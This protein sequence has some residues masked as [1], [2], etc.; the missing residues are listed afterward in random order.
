MSNGEPSSKRGWRFLDAADWVDEQFETEAVQSIVMN[1][2]S[3]KSRFLDAA[4]LVEPLFRERFPNPYAGET[5]EEFAARRARTKPKRRVNLVQWPPE[6]PERHG[7]RMQRLRQVRSANVRSA[8]SPTRLPGS[9]QT[10]HR[11]GTS[12]T[13]QGPLG[14]HASSRSTSSAQ[15]TTQAHGARCLPSE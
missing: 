14:T 5:D 12:G 10:V 13:L 8:T 11:A 2:T 3:S 6:T 15:E 4:E 7:E 1:D 9:D